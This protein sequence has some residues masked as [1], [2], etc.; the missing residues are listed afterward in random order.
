MKLKIDLG[1]VYAC[2]KRVIVYKFLYLLCQIMGPLEKY[3]PVRSLQHYFRVSFPSMILS[4]G[5][6][7]QIWE[8]TV[9]YSMVYFSSLCLLCIQC[10]LSQ[11]FNVSGWDLVCAEDEM[12]WLLNTMNLAVFSLRYVYPIKGTQMHERM[13]F[14][15]RRI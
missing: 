9:I 14:L 6:W 5:P 1:T 12:S 13:W 7:I 10:I 8:I 4:Y 11:P 3:C 15:T 2:I